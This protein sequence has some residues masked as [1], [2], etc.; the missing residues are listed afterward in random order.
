MHLQKEEKSAF[1]GEEGNGN[2][3]ATVLF[4]VSYYSIL[5]TFSI[6]RNLK[7]NVINRCQ[8]SRKVVEQYSLN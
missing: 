5:L 3:I 1:G 7:T 2:R 8:M 4:Y 6:R